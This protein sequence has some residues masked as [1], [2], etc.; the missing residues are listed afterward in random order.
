MEEQKTGGRKTS[1]LVWISEESRGG[2][3]V[4]MGERLE[5]IMDRKVMQIPMKRISH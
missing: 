2:I 4:S 5:Y 3:S 1:G